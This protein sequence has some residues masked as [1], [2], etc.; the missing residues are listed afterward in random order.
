MLFFNLGLIYRR[1]GLL[2]EALAA[3]ER[4]AAINPRPIPGGS[5]VRASEHRDQ[6]AAERREQE[7]LEASLRGEL[8][9]TLTVGSPDYH[10]R[11]AELLRARGA[12]TWARGHLLRAAEAAPR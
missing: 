5:H 7:A 8:G 10:R 4:S 11:V 12:P 9:E 3:F 6:V 2:P 1:N